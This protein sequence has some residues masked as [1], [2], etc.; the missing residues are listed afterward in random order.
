[1]GGYRIKSQRRGRIRWYYPPPMFAHGAEDGPR[2]LG[3]EPS[4]A[5]TRRHSTRDNPHDDLRWGRSRSG[6]NARH[7]GIPRTRLSVFP[8]ARQIVRPLI[9]RQGGIPTFPV[10]QC[11]SEHTMKHP[12]GKES[13]LWS[14]AATRRGVP[15]W[16]IQNPGIASG[17][18]RTCASRCSMAR[19]TTSDAG[20]G[21]NPRGFTASQDL[22]VGFDDSV[23]ALR[24]RQVVV[25]GYSGA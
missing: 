15:S 25:A 14:S 7:A 13:F 18:R 23:Y 10:W 17:L 16:T 11:G 19:D 1:M 2:W 4:K 9:R 24:E 3:W 21:Q 6:A 20:A 22:I 12:A 5:W 8:A